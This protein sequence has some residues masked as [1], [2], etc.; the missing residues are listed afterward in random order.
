M[1]NQLLRNVLNKAYLLS[2]AKA[3]LEITIENSSITNS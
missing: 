3:S 2:R 1:L